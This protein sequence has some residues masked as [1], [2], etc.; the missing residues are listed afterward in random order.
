MANNIL[1]IKEYTTSLHANDPVFLY[2][3]VAC[4]VATVIALIVGFVKGVRRVRLTGVAWLVAGIAYFIVRETLADSI[5]VKDLLQ[6]TIDESTLPFAT[7]LSIALASVVIVGLLY[8]LFCLLLRPRKEK[9]RK[10]ERRLRVNE[11]GMRYDD[12]YGNDGGLYDNRNLRVK[13]AKKKISFF[14]RLFG[15]LVCVVNALIIVVGVCIAFLLVVESAKAYVPESLQS[16]ALMPYVLK[17]G[18][19]LLIVG[20]LFAFMCKGT[21]VGFVEALR[22]LVVKFGG[23]LSLVLGIYLP[24]SPFAGSVP[25]VG[26]L[27]TRCQNLFAGF[28]AGEKVTYIAGGILAGLALFIIIFLV[29][30]LINFLLKQL[31]NLFQKITPVKAIDRGLSALIYIVYGLLVVALISF[32]LYLLANYEGLFVHMDSAIRQ[33]EI[34]GGIF[35]IFDVYVKDYVLLVVEKIQWFFSYIFGLFAK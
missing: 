28:G 14:G 26:G 1:S 16:A 8:G 15:A 24:F 32:V 19:D 21:Q 9:R 2:F 10:K 33:S 29:F 22:R 23:T 18:L 31:D 5:P 34:S 12:D 35:E 4:I 20:I 7:S 30:W 27:T 13:P 6:G 25:F 17:Y 3:L 11:I